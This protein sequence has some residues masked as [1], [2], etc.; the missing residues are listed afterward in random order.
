MRGHK[1]L[2]AVDDVVEVLA[3]HVAIDGGPPVASVAGARAVVDVEHDVALRR[4]EVVKH[5][6][7]EIR[8]PVFMRVLRVAGAVHEDDRGRRRLPPAS[9]HFGREQP[10][11]HVDA[12]A[13]FERQHLGVGPLERAPLLG[14]GR[15]DL[16]RRGARSVGHDVHLGRLVRVRVDQS[17]RAPVG[18]HD[19]R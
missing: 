17:E 4:E 3:A 18:R 1:I 11:V 6:F 13:R 2:R 16:P 7:A 12:V 19:S 10:R 8:G 5:V 15:G 14:R 9:Q